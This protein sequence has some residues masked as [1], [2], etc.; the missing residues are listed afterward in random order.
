MTTW[1]EHLRIAEE[2]LL[3]AEKHI[4]MGGD[5]TPSLIMES[6]VLHVKIAEVRLRASK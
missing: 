2:G 5:I 6:V 4:A 3:E 1:Q